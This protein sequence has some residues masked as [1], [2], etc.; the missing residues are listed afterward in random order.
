MSTFHYFRPGFDLAAE[1]QRREDV[2]VGE[3]YS[4]D[5][6][7]PDVGAALSR[8]RQVRL[9]VG[10]AGNQTARAGQI[11]RGLDLPADLV[12]TSA[13]WGV[14]KPDPAFFALV[15]EVTPA[16][17]DEI[18]YVGTIVTSIWSQLRRRDCA[19]RYTP[20]PLGIPMG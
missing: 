18:V 5:D 15:A 10:I 2:G 4:E 19:R 12:A 13:E 8:L 3:T 16:E 7:Y 9:W 17:P 6:L 11:L 1:R 20:G 14:A